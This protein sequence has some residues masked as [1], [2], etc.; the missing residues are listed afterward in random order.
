MFP[1]LIVQG[2]SPEYT[3]SL[4][5]REQPLIE[6]LLR[7]LRPATVLV[8][9]GAPKQEQWIEETLPCLARA[10][11]RIAAGLGGTVDFLAGALPRAPAVMRRVGLEWLYRLWCE[12][13]RWKRQARSLPMFALRVAFGRGTVKCIGAQS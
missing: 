4:P 11:V 1:R 6:A 3:S 9:L 12:P 2:V 13:S 10:D 5:L 8:C 7:S